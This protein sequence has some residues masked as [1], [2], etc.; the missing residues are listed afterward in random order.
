MRRLALTEDGK[1]LSHVSLE[2]TGHILRLIVDH[3]NGPTLRDTV[4]KSW[5]RI[6]VGSFLREIP[7]KNVQGELDACL[8]EM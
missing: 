7:H 3:D 1:N 4:L 5:V 6:D 8:G 2:A